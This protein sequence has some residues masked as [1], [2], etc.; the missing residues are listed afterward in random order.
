[1]GRLRIVVKVWLQGLLNRFGYRIERLI[2]PI[3]SID[4]FDLAVRKAM[5]ERGEQF[6]F[7]QI[8]AHDGITEDPIHRYVIEY[9]WAGL[10]VEP[11][12]KVFEHLVANYAGQSRLEFLNAAIAWKDGV[13]TLYTVPTN[14]LPS[15]VQ[16]MASFDSRLLLKQIPHGT[17]VIELIVRTVSLESLFRTR[18]ISRLDLLQIDTEGFDYEIIKMIDYEKIRPEI[19]H[20]EHIHLSRADREACEQLLASHGYRLHC[21]GQNTTAI[22][23]T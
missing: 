23:Q 21:S 22:I 7:V 1:M 10:L 16:G 12:P 19:I 5:A 11:Q 9:R 3:Q 17:P 8:G 20:Y 18:K 15:A 14:G 6:F 2:E 4:L 13:A